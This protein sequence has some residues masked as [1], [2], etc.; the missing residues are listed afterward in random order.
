MAAL[1]LGWAAVLPLLFALDQRL[2]SPRPAK[3]PA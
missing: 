2:A 1:A 3:A